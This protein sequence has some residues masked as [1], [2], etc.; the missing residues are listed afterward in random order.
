MRAVASIVIVVLAA[1]L[2]ATLAA[3]PPLA[4]AALEGY[5][6]ATHAALRWLAA[7]LP[8]AAG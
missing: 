8:H 3:N 7:L 4:H 6:A 2:V 1:G 5:F